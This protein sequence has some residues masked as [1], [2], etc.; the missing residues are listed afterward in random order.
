M[1]WPPECEQRPT[2]RQSQESIL[3]GSS[4]KVKHVVF[5][6]AQSCF[7]VCTYML[8]MHSSID[9]CMPLRSHL[10]LSSPL[11]LS[12]T[13]HKTCFH[14]LIATRTA[15]T[16]I[17]KSDDQQQQERVITRTAR[18]PGHYL[19]LHH[20]GLVSSRLGSQ[21]QVLPGVPGRLVMWRNARKRTQT[22]IDMYMYWCKKL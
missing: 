1:G 3:G 8:S 22:G 19:L 5:L 12:T 10:E 14:G 7:C 11:D 16:K 20:L 15:A 17:A 2:A 9:G 6:D 4:V 21:H 18:T 13:D